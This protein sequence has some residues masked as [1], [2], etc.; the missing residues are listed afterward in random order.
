MLDLVPILQPFVA[1]L[2]LQAQSEHFLV[3]YSLR[4]PEYGRGNILGGVRHAAF[5]PTVVDGLEHAYSRL[6]QPPHSRLAPV[7]NPEVGKTLVYLFDLAAVGPRFGWPFTASEADVN[8]TPFIC[9][10]TRPH[11]PTFDAV[12]Q[13]MSVAVRK[14]A[15]FAAKGSQLSGCKIGREIG[16]AVSAMDCDK[17]GTDRPGSRT[18]GALMSRFRYES[19]SLL[20]LFFYP[21]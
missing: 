11:H 8:R 19:F 15:T 1:E 14:G 18:W 5:V 21:V 6:I 2:N 9:L 16:R 3:R 7:V 13:Y 4:Q 17:E 10:P 12:M 20:N